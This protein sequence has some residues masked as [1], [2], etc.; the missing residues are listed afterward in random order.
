MKARYCHVTDAGIKELC[1]NIV[2]IETLDI[3]GTN[4]TKNGIRMVLESLPS[5]KVF[6]CDFPTELLA[7]LSGTPLERMRSTVSNIWLNSGFGGNWR[8]GGNELL[9]LLKLKT[10]S[11]LHIQSS[12]ENYA[13]L[14]FNG[15]FIPLLKHF[16]SSLTSLSIE[17][18]FKCPI[19]IRAIVENCHKLE[20]LTL[21][22]I[23]TISTE[24]SENEPNTSKRM[25]TDP[26][27]KN[28]K[29]LKLGYCY[30]MKSKDLDLL[31]ASP[32]L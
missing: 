18:I 29:I 11:K 25:K 32:A 6:S 2:P 27:L 5:L 17:E 4:V 15:G 19:D 9:E 13:E 10:L 21:V 20:S 1:N 14:T 12:L 8:I 16:G 23:W 22:N 3:L 26:V 30:D 28:L 24:Q 31:L 7:E